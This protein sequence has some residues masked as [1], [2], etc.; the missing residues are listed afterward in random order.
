MRFFEETQAKLSFTHTWWDAAN[1][2]FASGLRGCHLIHRL[3]V[4]QQTTRHTGDNPHTRSNDTRTLTASDMPGAPGTP[5]TP[6][7][8]TGA[9]ATF[10]VMISW[11]KSATR[12]TLAPSGAA[13][14]GLF[15]RE[16]LRSRDLHSTS[17]SH[18]THSSLSIS[19]QAR[20]CGSRDDGAIGTANRHGGCGA[21]H[22]ALCSCSCYDGVSY[23]HDHG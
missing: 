16:R 2:Q 14:F 6:S 19:S 17:K 11:I 5:G 3:N 21:S 23:H 15:E 10:F 12:M 18:E 8:L 22:D 20:T 7:G 9:G 13:G 1:V 4:L